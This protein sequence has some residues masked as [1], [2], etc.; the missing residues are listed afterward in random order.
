MILAKGGQQSTTNL[1]QQSNQTTAGLEVTASF[2]AGQPTL[3]DNVVSA[4]ASIG[5]SSGAGV[6]SVSRR[7]QWMSSP[8]VGSDLRSLI[9]DLK[10]STT[11]TT[12]LGL[13]DN[14][15]NSSSNNKQGLMLP[16]LEDKDIEYVVNVTREYPYQLAT[17]M[18][19]YIMPFVLIVTIITNLLVVM[20]LAQRHMR[21]PTNIVLF[22]MAIVDLLT[23]LSPSPW[24]FYIY[25]LNHPFHKSG[26]LYPASVCIAHHIMT[27]VIPVFFHTSSIWLAL[28]LAGQRYVYVCHPQTAR[29]W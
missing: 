21:T 15:S 22:A 5:S 13:I 10:N 26:I 6:G 3:I 7:D 23:L 11:T 14:N 25:T 29:K 2:A 18:F 20:V 4:V 24:Y 27:D 9:M 19:G 12:V 28:L 1:I 17:V 16:I 8:T